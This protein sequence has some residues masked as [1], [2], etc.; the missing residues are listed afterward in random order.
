MIVIID[1]PGNECLAAEIDH[2]GRRA[3]ERSNFV[4]CPDGRYSVLTDGNGFNDRKVGVDCQYVAVHE[5]GV[6]SHTC[7]RS[8]RHIGRRLRCT[9]LQ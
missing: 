4:S 3:R 1:Q 8:L 7:R 2:V 6:G 5:S 9:G